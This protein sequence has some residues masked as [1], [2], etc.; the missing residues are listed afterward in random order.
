MAKLATPPAPPWI[1][2]VSP[3]FSFNESSTERSAV[4]TGERQSRGVDMR[5]AA[6]LL[7]DE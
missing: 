3:D 7:R 1:R 4:R 5:Q 6:W 2:I